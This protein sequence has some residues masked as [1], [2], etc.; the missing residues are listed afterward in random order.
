MMHVWIGLAHCDTMQ[1][2]GPIL[3][4]ESW[5]A[6]QESDVVEMMYHLS[7]QPL[8]GCVGK[9]DSHTGHILFA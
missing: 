3:G 8:C 7:G 1:M 5:L 9:S 4:R 6:A 2:D